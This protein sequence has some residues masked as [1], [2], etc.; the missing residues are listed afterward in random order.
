MNVSVL[1]YFINQ[2]H[3]FGMTV[4]ILY[5]VAAWMPA[6][7]LYL[8]HSHVNWPRSHPFFLLRGPW[9]VPRCYFQRFKDFQTS[10]VNA[11]NNKPSVHVTETVKRHNEMTTH[12]RF[13]CMLAAFSTHF[14]HL[15]CTLWSLT[16]IHRVRDFFFL[17]RL[18]RA[19]CLH[20]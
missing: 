1:S 15:R 17:F 14:P 4:I 11:D 18:L 6:N 12:L 3:C 2:L 16:P 9:Y 10:D 19:T 8:Y 20:V 7:N 5:R 13:T